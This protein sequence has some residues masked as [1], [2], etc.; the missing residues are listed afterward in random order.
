MMPQAC[1]WCVDTVVSCVRAVAVPVVVY[2]RAKPFFIVR[3]SSIAQ[4]SKYLLT[5]LVLH[6]L[7]YLLTYL[8]RYTGGSEQY[9]LPV[10]AA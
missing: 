9:P 2:Q 7:T 6:W 10:Q 8:A 5:Y 4:V 3:L 1:V